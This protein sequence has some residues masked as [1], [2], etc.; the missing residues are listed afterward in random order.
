M[1]GLSIFSARFGN[2]AV[3]IALADAFFPRSDFVSFHESLPSPPF[4][5]ALQSDLHHFIRALIFGSRGLSTSTRSSSGT[6]TF[7]AIAM[8]HSTVSVTLQRSRDPPVSRGTSPERRHF[9]HVF[10]VDGL[11]RC[12]FRFS[13]SVGSTIVLCY[14][15]P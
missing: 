5:I 10:S 2:E 14:S 12:T 4:E 3:D 1:P 13:C 15:G 11:A 6:V 8:P 9:A 7:P